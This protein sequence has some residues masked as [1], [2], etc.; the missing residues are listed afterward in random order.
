MKVI[1]LLCVVAITAAW[2]TIARQLYRIADAL[3]RIDQREYWRDRD[4]DV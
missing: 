2:C 1:A 3:V 4:G